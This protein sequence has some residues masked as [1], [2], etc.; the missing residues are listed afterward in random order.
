M[1]RFLFLKSPVHSMEIKSLLP[2][3]NRFSTT[4]RY[5]SNT[6]KEKKKAKEKR[7]PTLDTELGA[8]PVPPLGVVTN[9]VVSPETDPLGNG[10]VLVGLLGQLLLGAESLLGRHRRR[11]GGEEEEGKRRREMGSREFC[12]GICI[13]GGGFGFGGTQVEKGR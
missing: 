8:P 1:P 13:G 7:T 5:A 3:P 2:P 6:K 11:A 9:L 4:H 12:M 10:A